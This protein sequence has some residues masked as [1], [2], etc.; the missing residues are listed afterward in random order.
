MAPTKEFEALLPESQFADAKSHL[1]AWMTSVVHDHRPLVVDRNR[2]RERAVLVDAGDLAILLEPYT[3]DP[4]VRVSDGDFVIRLPEFNLVASGSDLDEAVAELVELSERYVQNYLK[5]VDFYLQ[6]DRRRHLP[7]VLRVALT[8]PN[9]RRVLIAPD[10]P[11]V[12][13]ADV[14]R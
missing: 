6:T 1:S 14:A 5:R 3:F 7:W 13:A 8:P 9:M 11:G 2:G 12:L 4:K 10:I